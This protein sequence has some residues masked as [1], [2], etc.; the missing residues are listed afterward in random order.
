MDV[1]IG[2]STSQYAPHPG[3]L[4]QNVQFYNFKQKCTIVGCH[5]N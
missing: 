3:Q 5:N 2:L 1:K 4:E